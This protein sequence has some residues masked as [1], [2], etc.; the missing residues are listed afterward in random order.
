MKLA[1]PSTKRAVLSIGTNVRQSAKI[2]TEPR[3]MRGFFCFWRKVCDYSELKIEWYEITVY[4]MAKFMRFIRDVTRFPFAFLIFGAIAWQWQVLSLSAQELSMQT[5]LEA[6]DLAELADEAARFGDPSRGAFVYFQPEMNCARCHETGGTGRRLGPMLAEK[7]E[8]SIEH[9]V[10]SILKPSLEIK[11]GYESAIVQTLDGESLTGILVEE[12]E[13]SL[14]LD[15]I[16]EPEKPLTVAKEEIDQWKRSKK[17]SMPEQLVNQLTSRQQFLDLVSYLS[18]LSK[19]G[20]SR[21]KELRPE[22]SL[23]AIAP[24]PEYELRV[25][26]KKL[27][28]SLNRDSFNR[29]KE[30]FRL[31]C[32]SCHGTIDAEG[33][34]PTSLRFAEGKFKRGSDPYS[35]YQTLTHGYGM[36]NPQRWMVPKQKYD[37]IH[38]I[39]EHFLKPRN[40]SQYFNIDTTYLAGLPAGDTLGPEPIVR[41]PWS[42]M[43]YG[44]SLNNTIEVSR[45]GSNIAQKGMAIRLDSGPGGVES[46]KYW[47][48]YEHDTMR[49]ASAWTGG[50]I[51]YNG[52]HFNGVHGRHP[53]IAGRTMLENPVMPGWGRP[54]TQSF[55]G[56]R[57]K[58][59]DGKKYGPLP[60]DW[61][62]FKGLYRF[63]QKTILEYSVGDCSIVESPAMRFIEGLPVVSRQFNI[64]KR[65]QDLVL[66]VMRTDLPIQPS[67]SRQSL[68]FSNAKQT[69]IVTDK[70]ELVFDGD[71]YAESNSLQFD[72]TES[73]FTIYAEIKSGED[74]TIFSET[75]KGEEWV[76]NGKTFF[77]RNGRLHYDIGWVG[78]VNSRVPVD[79][80][81][82]QTV[83]M[84]WQEDSGQVQFYAGG[85]LLD[86]RRIRPDEKLSNCVHRIG[87][88]NDDFPEPSAFNGGIRNLRLYSRCLTEEELGDVANVKNGLKANWDSPDDENFAWVESKKVDLSRFGN[89]LVH[90]A[91]P[92]NQATWE[93][94]EEG[95]CRLR[96]VAGEEPLRFSI[97]FVCSDD[98]I[99]ATNWTSELEQ[100]GSDIDLGRMTSGGIANWPQ[101]LRTE[102]VNGVPERGFQVDVL[103]RPVENPWNDR[104]RVTGIDFF[105]GGKNAVVCCWDGSVYRVDGI[106]QETT[107]KTKTITWRRIAAGLFQPLGVRIVDGQIFVTCRDQLVRLNDLDGDGEVDFYENFNSDHQVTEHFHEFA[108]GLQTDDA[109]NFYYAK[110]ARH[111]LPAVVPHHG[112]LLKVSND[113]SKTEIVAN[114]FRAANGVCLNPDGTFIV[115]DQEGHWNPKNRVNWVRKGGFYGNMYG[116]HDVKDSSDD[117]MDQPLCW[118]TNSF[119]RSPGELMWVTSKKWDRLQGSLLSLSYGTGQIYI[120]PHEQIGEQVQGG[121]CPLPMKRFPTGIMRGRFNPLDGQLYCCGMFAWSGDQ[122]QPGGLYR[123]RYTGEPMH[124]PVELSCRGKKVALIFSD[125]LDAGSANDARNFRVETWDLKRTRNYGSKHYNEQRVSIDSSQL[126][127][128]KK[129]VVLEI[130]DLKETWCM[131]IQYSL[132]D[133]E[134]NRFNGEIHNTIHSLEPQLD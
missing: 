58:G 2:K 82:W 126:G 50:F 118:I 10:T 64:G 32:A 95:D 96:I 98:Q 116:Y 44:P 69:P 90:T 107:E 9:L 111:A 114:G 131:R 36:M 86:S 33:S 66:Q 46:G 91:L 71:G 75:N 89:V 119:D 99:D 62:D 28:S 102:V 88:T 105:D 61:L 52:I 108:M 59:R 134:G 130:P 113:G 31:R 40:E 54:G 104:L 67:P 112:T 47:M 132:K 6:E 100:V 41:R 121:V 106:D 76:A 30:I 7:R 83:A 77:I 79:T 124:L 4:E 29:G 25:D 17:S 42:D 16:E 45:D 39:R 63:G 60:E 51:D 15:R 97:D 65:D 78:V 81:T 11:K 72:M 84:T 3:E 57:V 12:T 35:M 23:L 34:L 94:T 80:E 92:S 73:D 38:Y 87:F 20:E 49:V 120:V 56:E 129:T 93:F 101:V 109:G 22:A 1:S 125:E 18:E 122:Q 68:V 110:S 14:I 21:A 8:V 115:T 133:L 85:R 43:D 55:D 5:N 127:D 103:K 123:V 70:S 26:H 74:G 13:R 37:V 128:D 117:A 48:L 19:G 24:L 27:L 53:K